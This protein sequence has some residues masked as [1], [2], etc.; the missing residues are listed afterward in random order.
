VL[1]CVLLSAKSF[2]A[3]LHET[4]V[5][6]YTYFNFLRSKSCKF[7]EAVLLHLI[8][9]HCKPFLL[10]GM[11]AVNNGNSELNPLNY[12]YSKCRL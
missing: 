12:I 10:H 9:A 8:S 11:E 5:K 4:R 2:K 6:F 3:S 1:R 7:T